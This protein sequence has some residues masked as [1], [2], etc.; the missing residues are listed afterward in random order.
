[1][2]RAKKKAQPAKVKAVKQP[3]AEK[4]VEAEQETQPVQE[5]EAEKPVESE[6]TGVKKYMTVRHTA[7]T[8]KLVPPGREVVASQFPGGQDA[9]DAHVRRGNVEVING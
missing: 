4:P 5:A 3:E 1:M 9:L 8:L 7:T 2:P 6:S